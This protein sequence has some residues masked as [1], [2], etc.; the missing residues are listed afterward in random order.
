MGFNFSSIAKTSGVSSNHMLRAYEIH[1]VVLESAKIEDVEIKNGERAGETVKTIKVRFSNNDGYF[2]ETLWFPTTDRD[3]ERTP[4]QWGGENP[5]NFDRNMMF[6]AHVVSTLSPELFKK[7]QEASAKFKSFDDVAKFFVAVC[8]KIKGAETKLKLVGRTSQGNVR[9][10]I[11]YFCA[12]N[13]DG[14][15]YIKDNFLGEKVAFSSRELTAK[16]NFENAKPTAMASDPDL[17]AVSSDNSDLSGDD[18]SSMID[19]LDTSDL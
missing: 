14:D 3:G 11:P 13:K 4:N 18:I 16:A 8:E 15:A 1:D 10:A 17:D 9:P 12:V 2:E 7:M 5:S 19:D 6:I